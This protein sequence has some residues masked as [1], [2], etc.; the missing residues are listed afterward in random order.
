[1]S[2]CL[3]KLLLVFEDLCNFVCVHFYL[4]HQEAKIYRDFWVP[5]KYGSSLSSIVL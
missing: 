2:L 4:K 3:Y 5:G 1:M